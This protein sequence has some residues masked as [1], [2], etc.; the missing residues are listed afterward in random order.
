MDFISMMFRLID[1]NRDMSL[2][3]I[4]K[5]SYAHTLGIHHPWV[6]RQAAK[7]AMYAIPSRDTLIH[8][9]G[10]TFDQCKEIT[11]NA[12]LIRNELWA[13]YQEHKLENLP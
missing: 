10:L 8:T 12:D 11:S 4:A 3:N 7:V 9:T 1:E 2:C 6:V 5:E 13:F